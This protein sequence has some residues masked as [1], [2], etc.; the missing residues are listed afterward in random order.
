MG[1]GEVE[2]GWCS[3]LRPNRGTFPDVCGVQIIILE[4]VQQQIEA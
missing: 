2:E 4:N 1:L 3:A